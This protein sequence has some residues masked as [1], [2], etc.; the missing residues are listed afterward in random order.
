MSTIIIKI[1][2]HVGVS[3]HGRFERRLAHRNEKIVNVNFT[4]CVWDELRI[5]MGH[6]VGVEWLI[7][8]AFSTRRAFSDG[9]L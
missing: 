3:S 9:V 4:L 6:N 8:G 1:L 7:L 2:F 5:L